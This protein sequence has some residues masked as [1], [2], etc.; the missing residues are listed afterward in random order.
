MQFYNTLYVYLNMTML[1][2]VFS[3]KQRNIT[4][5]KV[6]IG[7]ERVKQWKQVDKIIFSQTSWSQTYLDEVNTLRYPT[8]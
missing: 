7:F 3:F 2:M 8:I 4:T 5:E 1:E 6:T